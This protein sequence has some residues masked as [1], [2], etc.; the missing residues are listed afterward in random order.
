[1][2]ENFILKS[3]IF[4][5]RILIAVTQTQ[6][7][8]NYILTPVNIVPSVN[9]KYNGKIEI[10]PNSRTAVYVD[11][12]DG[13]SNRYG[14]YSVFFAD[15]DAPPLKTTILVADVGFPS[16]CQ[17][18]LNMPFVLYNYYYIALINTINTSTQCTDYLSIY[19]YDNLGVFNLI[20]QTPTG[21]NTMCMSYLIK[22]IVF[23]SNPNVFSVYIKW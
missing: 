21:L 19:Y 20:S 13:R 15:N 8:T 12:L 1:M 22:S 11:N 3:L 5:I 2:K 18:V 9:H 14:I 17:S 23:L 4:L 6:S 10:I 7:P 16:N